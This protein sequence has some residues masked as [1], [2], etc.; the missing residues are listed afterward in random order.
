MPTIFKVGTY[1]FYCYSHEPNEP[2]H[3]YIDRDHL[4]AKFW[5][6]PVSL[7]SNLGF[8]AKELNKLTLLVIEHQ[9]TLLEKWYGYFSA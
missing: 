4:S 9:D 1:R 8:K 3:I 2:P 6:K 7:I 5:L